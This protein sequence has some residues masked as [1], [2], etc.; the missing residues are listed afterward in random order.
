MKNK[1]TLLIVLTALILLI[2]GAGVLYGKLGSQLQMPQLNITGEGTSAEGNSFQSESGSG[3]VYGTNPEGNTEGI[4]GTENDRTN[5]EENSATSTTEDSVPDIE[6]VPDFTVYDREGNE[7]QLSDFRGK[8][9]ILNFWASWCGPCKSEMPDF[10]EL[11]QEYGED[12]HFLMINM[13]DGYQETVESAG[14]FLEKSQYTFP[15]Y[16]DLDYEAAV[17]YGVTSLPTTF[18]IDAEGY[19]VAYGIGAMTRDKLL[20]GISYLTI[21]SQE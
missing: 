21:P 7:V 16:F 10:E 9:I 20:L 12:I 4:T 6:K 5:K 8:P 17:A 2:A 11:Y 18:F 14:Q 3:N 13:T 19:G 15:V 1:R